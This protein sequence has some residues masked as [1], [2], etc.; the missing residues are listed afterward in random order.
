MHQQPP[1][2]PSTSTPHSKDDPQPPQ[3]TRRPPCGFFS[4]R[5]TKKARK[6]PAEASAAPFKQGVSS[7]HSTSSVRGAARSVRGGAAQQLLGARAAAE[8]VALGARD[9]PCSKSVAAPVDSAPNFG[10]REANT[11]RAMWWPSAAPKHMKQGSKE[12]YSVQPSRR[13]APRARR[14]AW[15]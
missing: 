4:R 1:T 2:P 9:E 11:T 13:G 12:T 7:A 14:G 15:E 5:A 6:S 10:E 8:G 3:S